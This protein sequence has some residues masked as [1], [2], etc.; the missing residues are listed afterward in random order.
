MGKII[1]NKLILLLALMVFLLPACILPASAG[2]TTTFSWETDT[3]TGTVNG[4]STLTETVDGIDV[5]VSYDKTF[6]D[7]LLETNGFLE[8]SGFTGNILYMSPLL[9]STITFSFSEAVDISSIHAV[10]LGGVDAT[11]TYSPSG[12]SNL[13][14]TRPMFNGH[15]EFVPFGWT[16]VTSFTVSTTNMEAGFYFDDLVVSKSVLPPEIDSISPNSGSTAGSTDVTITGQYFTGANS[17]LIG[18][19]SASNVTVVNDTTITA[20]TPT[21]TPGAKDVA[22]TTSIGTGTGSGLYTYIADISAAGVTGM[23]APAAGA[24]PIAADSLFPDASYYTVTGLTWQNGDGSPATLT[25]SGKFKAGSSYK[26]VVELTSAA[27]YKFQSGGIASPSVNTGMAGA[28]TVVGGDVEGNRLTYTVTFPATAA[29]SVSAIAVKTQP[30]TLTYI[31]G[32]TLSLSGLEATLTYNDGTTADV[33]YANFGAN[34]I[35]ASP[36]AGTALTVADHNEHPVTLTCNTHTAST[37]SLTVNAQLGAASVTIAAPAAG[38]VPQDTAAVETVTAN[39][40][41]TVSGVVWNEALTLGGRFKAGQTYTATITLTSKNGT[42]FQPAAFTPAVAGAASVS[43]TATS[44]GTVTGNAV[45]FTVTYASTAPLSVTGIAV[46]AQPAK[47]SYT[48]V[49]DGTLALNGMVITETYNDGSSGSVSFIGGTASGYTADPANGT[50]L[51]NAV[52]N[53]T[54]VTV[55]HM[56]TGIWAE[57]DALTV[58]PA[59]IMAAGVTGLAAPVTGSTPITVSALNSND[60]GSYMVTSLTWQNGDGSPATLTS[61]VKFRANASYRAEIELT[62]AAGHKFPLIGFAPGVNTGTPQAGMINGG[63]VSGN[64]LIFTVTFP[65]TGAKAVTGITVKT[66]PSDLAYENGETLSLAGLM[67]TLTYSDDTVLDVEFANFALNGITASPTDGTVMAYDIHNGQKV[68]LHCGEYTA[69]TNA[70]TVSPPDITEAGVTGII[71]PV[72]GSA[73]ISVSSL[74]SNDSSSY[75][76]TSLTWQNGDGVPATLTSGGKFREISSYRAAIVLTS[77]VGHKFPAGALTPTADAGSP[78]AGTVSGG[79]VTGNTLTFTVTFPDTGAKEVTGIAVKTQPSELAYENGETLN[80]SG[81]VATL[82]YSDDTALDVAL[83]NFASN[84]IYTSPAD[85]TVLAYAIHNGQKV[86]LSC[87]SYTAETNDLTVIPPQPI[88]TPGTVNRTSDTAATVTFT[89]DQA[90]TYYF[91]IVADGAGTPDVST[92]G[93]GSVCLTGEST[94]SLTALTAGDRDIYIKVKSAAGKVSET[95]KMDIAAY[96]VPVT[97]IA[98]LPGLAWIGTGRTLTGTVFPENA[99]NKTIVWSVKN[100]GATGA[101]I[102]GSTFTATGTG[103]AVLT[104][105]IDKGASSTNDYTQDFSIE[106]HPAMVY[107]TIEDHV[108]SSTTIIAEGMFAEEARLIVT[109]MAN[110]DADRVELEEQL[111]EQNAV[112]AYEVHVEPAEAFQPPLT[113]TFQVGQSFN[114][115]TVYIL[116]KLSDGSIDIYTPT[117]ADGE[118]VI[119][120][121]ELSPFLLAVDPQISIIRQPLNVLIL[122]GQTATFHVEANGLD[123]LSYQW[124]RRTGAGAVWEDIPGATG[125]DYT[126]TKVNMS[127]NGYQ[128]RVVVTDVLGNSAA[129]DTVILTVAVSPATGDDSQPI[130]YIMLTVMFAV[131]AILLYKKRRTA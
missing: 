25:G 100:A 129:S 16:N 114:G 83:A 117:V 96:F 122:T 75:M 102:S 31:D 24:A 131:A 59:D 125:A 23:P 94:I 44:G 47:M 15:V 18:G 34:S 101:A 28:G 42:R 4:H 130:L 62:S 53:G 84:G 79:N 126:T 38:A 87:G 39:A 73:P 57:T 30:A 19:A 106:V 8:S 66:Q 32:D 68:L 48:E 85:G 2:S 120:V 76:V 65:D 115:R 72:T 111:S 90:G 14:L 80:L 105:T 51:T 113:L 121:N 54:K 58:S 99:T 112:A 36:D 92:A 43:G 33:V 5:V 52:H 3:L 17:V 71:A 91:G 29:L 55:T 46:T 82:T 7:I 1:R 107:N 119:T 74:L 116:H 27:G 95:L 86:L 11:W 89:S 64:T 77:A 88:L 12:G 6:P 37:S 118:A 69:Q 127:H 41:Y 10:N 45:T 108:D 97:G 123:P 67:A 98:D 124:Q 93:Q 20:K 13:I 40:N 56:A 63:D 61:G 81:L 21:G 50:A 60:S 128:Y 49:E 78:Q 35:T 104:A 109:P 70:L 110:G 9:S 26:A 103:T 22:V